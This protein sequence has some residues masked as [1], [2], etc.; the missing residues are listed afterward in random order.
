MAIT[1]VP[2]FAHLTDADIESLAVELDAIRLDIFHRS[3][4]QSRHFSWMRRQDSRRAAVQVF[5]RQRIQRIRINDHREVQLLH[6]APDKLHRVGMRSE[7][8]PDRRHGLLLRYSGQ[9]AVVE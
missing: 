9:Q 4:H 6:D 8:R 2:A 5:P 1:E 7:P 3:R